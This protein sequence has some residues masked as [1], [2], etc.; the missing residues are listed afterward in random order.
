M[1]EVTPGTAAC[2]RREAWYGPSEPVMLAAYRPSKLV[3][4]AA[5]K[6]RSCCMWACIVVVAP[7]SACVVGRGWWDMFGVFLVALV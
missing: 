3:A 5:A 1:A 4:L 2:R 6:A 7:G